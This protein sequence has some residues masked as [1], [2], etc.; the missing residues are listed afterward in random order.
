[1]ISLPETVTLPMQ[2]DEHGVIR[3]SG[4]RVTFDSVIGFYLQGETP[5]ALH[6]LALYFE[7][8]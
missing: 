6:K 5:E 1:M 3:I 2:T 4:T 7:S 8:G